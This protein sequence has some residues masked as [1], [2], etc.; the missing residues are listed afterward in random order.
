MCSAQPRSAVV[1]STPGPVI[2]NV[3]HLTVS[4]VTSMAQI[5]VIGILED[6][7]RRIT[8]MSTA[9]RVH[10]PDFVP[11][12]FRS[13]WDMIDWLDQRDADPQLVSLDCDLDPQ[14]THDCGSGEDV[15]NYLT[16]HDVHCPIVIHSSN[17]MRAPAMHMELTLAGYDRVLLCPFVDDQLWAADVAKA[18][19]Q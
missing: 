16:T 1:N 4:Q 17:A 10:F 11:R 3:M 13:A 15:T 7:E 12:I 19:R 9:F 14:G 5:S 8:G 6:D 2:S 18:L